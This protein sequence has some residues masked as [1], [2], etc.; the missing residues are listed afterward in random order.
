MTTIGRVTVMPGCTVVANIEISDSI[1]Y[2]FLGQHYYS[3]LYRFIQNKHPE[4]FETF[5]TMA[6]EQTM[7]DC[8]GLNIEYY[9]EKVH[10]DHVASVFGSFLD[11]SDGDWIR[12]WKTLKESFAVGYY[13]CTLIDEKFLSYKPSGYFETTDQLTTGYEKFGTIYEVMM[14]LLSDPESSI[15]RQIY[16]EQLAKFRLFR[17]L[18][19]DDLWRPLKGTCT[20]S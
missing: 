11:D 3:Q 9:F 19:S 1:L 17:T 14:N 16:T 13:V 20:I 6:A 12:T 8:G 2:T 5:K 15:Y 10:C 4:L 18:L 7:K